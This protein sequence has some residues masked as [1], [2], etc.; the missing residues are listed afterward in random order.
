MSLP[1]RQLGAAEARRGLIRA[2]GAG[3]GR[4]RPRAASL[5]LLVAGLFGGP[6]AVSGAHAF[7]DR[8]LVVA[9]GTPGSA[10]MARLERLVADA[11]CRLVD[12]DVDV[13]FVDVAELD[14]AGGGAAPALVRLAGLRGADAGSFE[15]VL[16]GKDGG[17]K[18]RADDPD[19]LSAFLERIDTM[20]MRRAE[21]RRRGGPDAAC[22]GEPGPPS[23]G[24]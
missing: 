9:F 13:R 24:G 3:E 22:E 18:A 23:S 21:I 11:R 1:A 10:A 19:A 5:F 15:L 7:D 6:L 12:R 20:P 17:V 2:S 4:R 8:R 16:V 14:S